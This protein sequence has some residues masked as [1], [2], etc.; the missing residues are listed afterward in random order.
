MISI[1]KLNNIKVDVIPPLSTVL[2]VMAIGL[3][4]IA[5]FKLFKSNKGRIE[6]AE[7]FGVSWN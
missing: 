3:A 7:H 1:D 5:M 6:L 4:T 2:A